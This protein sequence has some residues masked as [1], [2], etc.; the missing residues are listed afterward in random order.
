MLRSF[1]NGWAASPGIGA[2]LSLARAGADAPST[3][4]APDPNGRASQPP[5]ANA[6][7]EEFARLLDFF[8]I[9]WEYEPVEFPL[10]YE[11]GK[12]AEA[13][14]PDFFLP[15]LDLFIE[16]TTM[17]QSLV[18]AKNRKL[19][20]LREQRRDVNVK[21]LYKSDYHQILAAHGFG[22]VEPA[23]LDQS[24]IQEVLFSP[25]EIAMRVRELGAQISSD[26]RD[27][28]ITLV[29]LL[30]GVAFFMADLARSITVPV[31]LDY[32][33]TESY[34][35]GRDNGGLVRL[36]KDLDESI[37]ERDVLVV[38]DVMNTGMTL[39]FLMKVL[40]DRQPASLNVCT[41]LDKR[42]SHLAEVP[43]AY[44]GFEIPS[45]YVVGYGLDLGERYRNLP[46]ICTLRPEAYDQT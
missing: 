10:R 9:A 46:F 7:E 8:H 5:F 27:R 25:H 22:S 1:T 40:R 35:R 13:F 12:L 30:K 14:A 26:Y 45:V 2:A 11:N 16:L 39:N 18:T 41:L 4:H 34:R 24:L 23:H 3:N 17:R 44:V 29:G 38:E 43:L 33:A 15:E 6:S 42:D 28:T 32:I 21:L 20:L 36:V 37:H 31:A 19:R